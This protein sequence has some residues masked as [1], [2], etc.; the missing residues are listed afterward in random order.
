[1]TG[2]SFSSFRVFSF[3][4]FKE[5]EKIKFKVSKS[6]LSGQCLMKPVNDEHRFKFVL[7]NLG[8]GLLNLLCAAIAIAVAA[9]SNINFTSI[10]SLL[11]IVSLLVFIIMQIYIGLINLIPMT[12]I[13]K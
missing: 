10:T 6:F 3:I 8:G 13:R 9:V 11:F 2:Y 5:G 12:L 1:M 7:Y 4:W